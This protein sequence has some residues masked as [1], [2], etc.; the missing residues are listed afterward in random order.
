MCFFCYVVLPT[1]KKNLV[2]HG[3]HIQYSTEI[4]D[5]SIYSLHGV[6]NIIFYFIAGSLDISCDNQITIQP[7]WIFKTP[8]V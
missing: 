5:C 8:H 2:G 1:E 7:D 4:W 6:L 3:F